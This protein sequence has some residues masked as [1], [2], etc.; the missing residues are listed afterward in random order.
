[1]N[2]R[3]CQQNHENKTGVNM[4]LLQDKTQETKSEGKADRAR[5]RGK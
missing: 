2:V 3:K 5:E 4:K 1:M